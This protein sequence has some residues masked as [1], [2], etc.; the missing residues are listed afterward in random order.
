MEVISA[1]Q[2]ERLCCPVLNVSFSSYMLM[3]NL[4]PTDSEEP[5]PNFPQRTSGFG[6]DKSDSLF[7]FSA[8]Y[9]PPS[10]SVMKEHLQTSHKR[11]YLLSLF[12]NV[13]CLCLKV[14]FP[15]GP[16]KGLF[17]YNVVKEEDRGLRGKRRKCAKEKPTEVKKGVQRK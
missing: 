5:T 7:F 13:S 16:H 12:R 8:S 17:F 14:V 2:A 6:M 15:S 3:L 11:S 4:Q 10:L 9:H 1:H